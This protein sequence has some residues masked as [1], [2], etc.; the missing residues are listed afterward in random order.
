MPQTAAW[1]T[2][3]AQIPTC[4]AAVAVV[5]VG[6]CSPNLAPSLGTSR[7]HTYSP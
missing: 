2:D 1:V 6:S 7:C 3:E 4:Q 5:Q